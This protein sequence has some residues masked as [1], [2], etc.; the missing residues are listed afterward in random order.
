LACCHLLTV[1]GECTSHS[2]LSNH[3]LAPALLARFNNGLL[4]RFIRGRVCSPEDLRTPEIWRGVASRLAE[5]HATLPTSAVLRRTGSISDGHGGEMEPAAA[6]NP[7]IS[8]LKSPNI[9]D[10][11]DRW[12]DNIPDKTEPHKARKAQLKSELAWLID[13]VGDTPGINGLPR[14]VFGHCDLLSGNVI[15][16]PPPLRAASASPEPSVPQSPR[17]SLGGSPGPSAEAAADIPADESASAGLATDTETVAFIDYEYAT[18]CPAAFDIANHFAEWGGFDC[19]FT[20]LP[21]KSQRRDFLKAYMI[22]F[23]SFA[24]LPGDGPTK[25]KSAE[26]VQL[27]VDQIMSQ[28]DAFRGAPGF[29][30]GIWA[31]IQ[32]EISQI[33]FDY[34]NYAEIRLGEYFAWKE[35]VLAGLSGRQ[36]DEVTIREKRWA[37]E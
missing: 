36:V 7:K 13:Q 31:L 17:S 29:Y 30:W 26:V 8:D 1:A 18:P 21:T 32:A 27:E 9:W 2:L 22:S 37:E 11:M 35:A 23:E 4:Y 10:V 34:A 3:N 14:L 25:A 5:W 20:V 6:K 28:V 24:T 33:D 12:V 19:D 15:V 16:T